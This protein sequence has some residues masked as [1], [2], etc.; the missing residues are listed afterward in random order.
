MV[1]YYS[2]IIELMQ[3]CNL[4]LHSPNVHMC[5]YL[6]KHMNMYVYAH[7]AHTLLITF[8]NLVFTTPLTICQS[9]YIRKVWH[10]SPTHAHTLLSEK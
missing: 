5:I 1:I 3:P 7:K 8:L 6:H 4:K 9:K 2:N 10:T